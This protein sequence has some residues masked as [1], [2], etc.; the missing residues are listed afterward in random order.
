MRR[1]QQAA[2]AAA[3]IMSAVRPLLDGAAGRE[4]ERERQVPEGCA[5][6]TRDW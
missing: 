5:Q 4:R 6:P 3:A 2:E 1:K